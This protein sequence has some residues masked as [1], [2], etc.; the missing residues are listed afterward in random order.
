MSRV[1]KEWLHSPRRVI[2]LFSEWFAPIQPDWPPQLRLTG[3]P[4]YDEPDQQALSTGLHTFLDRGLPPI[5][6][7]PG[8]AN[9]AA[10]QFFLA[11]LDATRRLGRRALFLTRLGKEHWQGI[12]A[13]AHVRRERASWD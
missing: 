2:G 13:T 10:S 7:T 9:R 8:S 11:A 1:F 4:L 12:D 5:L 3:F 6:F